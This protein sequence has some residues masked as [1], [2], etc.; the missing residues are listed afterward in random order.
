MTGRRSFLR[1]VAVAAGAAV[2]GCSGGSG[3][4]TNTDGGG[5]P[6]PNSG[7]TG[8]STP[9]SA[10]T[11]ARSGTGAGTDTDVPFPDLTADDPTYRE[12]LPAD[13]EARMGNWAAQNLSRIR[14]RRN[15]LP[16]TDYESGMSLVSAGD[17]FGVAAADM[18]GAIGTITG[19]GTV[20]PGSFDRA[21]VDATLTDS[22]YEQF[23]TRGNVAFYRERATAEPARFAVGDA[24]VVEDQYGTREA[25]RDRTV[26][27]FETAAGDRQRLHETDERFRRYSN[28]VGWPLG[29]TRLIPAG[30][31]MLGSSVQLPENV[32]QNAAVGQ[33]EHVVDGATVSRV[34]LL[35]AADSDLSPAEVRSQV[36]SGA[37]GNLSA[38]IDLAVRRDGRV[39]EAAVIRPVEN[40][41]GGVDPPRVTLDASV[42]DG[43]LRLANLAGD[44]LDLARVTVRVG[45]DTYDV[46]GSLAAGELTAVE[47]IPTDTEDTIR[48]IYE[49]PSGSGSVTLARVELGS[50]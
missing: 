36:E 5:G 20:Y 7:G 12:W 15:R 14:S 47:G 6:E 49:S 30:S 40:A 31:G 8:T 2:A 33:A 45:T 19:P 21:T 39:V 25:F 29:T 41:G 23:D 46:E 34:W 16:A 27:L 44:T 24:G 9:G 35:T 37:G 32:R 4:E 48:V 50:E 3:N 10:S 38:D 22:G 28:A 13:G 43:S 1:A 18:T 11:T 42:A 17:Y 26:V